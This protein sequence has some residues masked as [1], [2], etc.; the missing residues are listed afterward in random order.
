M[1][2]LMGYIT[3]PTQSRAVGSVGMLLGDS[4]R[5]QVATLEEQVQYT[6]NEVRAMKASPEPDSERVAALEEQLRSL[7]VGA[8]PC[9]L[10]LR[11]HARISMSHIHADTRIRVLPV[12]SVALSH[13]IPRHSA[14][15][16]SSDQTSMSSPSFR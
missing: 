1:R 10:M 3:L 9:T 6:A 12:Q 4:V 15:V 16:C 5:L 8:R 7:Q 11:I 14:T 13:T 2:G